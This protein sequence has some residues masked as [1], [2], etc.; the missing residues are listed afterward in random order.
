MGTPEFAVPSLQKLI[1]ST[2]L[3]VGVVTRPN[4]PKGRGLRVAFSP[5]KRLALE[6]GIP[7]AQP[8]DL[9]DPGFQRQL[10]EW[11]ADCFLVVAFR[12]LPPE[13]FTLPR[14]GTVNLHA[15]LLPRYRGAAPIQW[16]VIN[17]ETETGVT[18]F[19]IERK[20]DTGDW[21]LQERTPIGPGETAGELHDRLAMVGADCLLKTVHL[22]AGGNA[23][24]VRQEGE[25]TPAPKITPEHCRI[26]WQRPAGD[27]VNLIRGLSP[28]PGAYTVWNGKRLKLFTAHSLPGDDPQTAPGTV[29][30]ADEEGLT[31]ASG[32]GRVLVRRVQLECG[33]PMP[34]GDFLRGHCVVAGTFLGATRPA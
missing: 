7:V 3:V 11:N 32:N 4:R 30:V 2:H 5:I 21:I 29:V 34:A 19:F 13:V 23:V 33:Q 26:N 20:V 6:T 12:I 31:V 14:K 18:T 1:E 22:I 27:V 25:V 17:G 28:H 16:A 10:K 24:R 8:A 9:K 15:S